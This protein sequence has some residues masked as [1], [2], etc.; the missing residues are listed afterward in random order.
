M[1]S[2]PLH[3]K[4]LEAIV[5]EL[6]EL[7]GF[8]ELA[9][10]IPINCFKNNPS[11]KSSLTFLRRTPWARAKVE[12]LYIASL[13]EFKKKITIFCDFDG[14]VTKRDTI[15]YLLELHALP[16]WEEIEN[17]W[18]AGK[19]GSKECLKKQIE[20]IP[21]FTESDFDAFIARIEID[22][23]FQVFYEKVLQR[24]IPFYII[25]DGMDLVIEKVFKKY[26]L[27]TPI[28][29]S[30]KIEL[31]HN[32]LTISFPA[33]NE[34]KCLVNAGMCKCAIIE[35]AKVPVTYI[36]DGRSD[37]CASR[38]VHTL[39]AKGTLQK[40]CDEINKSYI[41]FSNFSDIVSHLFS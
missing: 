29:Y 38:I 33:S 14:T 12:N 3:G 41:P 30:N 6:V 2:N 40:L 19:I 18:K 27:P 37:F 15:D 36:G 26:H 8:L 39:Y 11:I 13:S 25:S 35:K 23:H 24:K 32:K 28:I 9:D 1:N 5:T 4:T 22:E 20:C 7:Y 10:L 17:E 31:N 21:H 34:G 16:Q